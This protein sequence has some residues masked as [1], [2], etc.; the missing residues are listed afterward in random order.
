M[1]KEV[2]THVRSKFPDIEIWTDFN[3]FDF[4][5]LLYMN[6][7]DIKF[8]GNE[9]IQRLSL[10]FSKF[11]NAFETINEWSAIKKHIIN[12]YDNINLNEIFYDLFEDSQLY[13]N[14]KVLFEILI[15]IPANTVAC[16]QS[17]SCSNRI[18]T[19]YCSK[20]LDDTL[21]NRMNISL[22]GV[23]IKNL[24][25]QFNE[26][27]IRYWYDRKERRKIKKEK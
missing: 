21:S 15:S 11:V 6:D 20:M 19:K 27:V 1:A 5:K 3:I 16:E 9:S 8:Y 22:N 10:R 17:F 2:I 25:D 12:T 26:E 13:P 18:K 7:K 14:M 23:D 4:T 24:D